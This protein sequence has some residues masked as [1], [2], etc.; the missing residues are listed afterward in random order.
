MHPNFRTL[1][2]LHVGKV[3][4]FLNIRILNNP[5]WLLANGRPDSLAFVSYTAAES[6]CH[7][8]QPS[9]NGFPPTKWHSS[10]GQG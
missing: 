1:S 6:G 10:L 8:P 5:I 7:E 3:Y 2:R 4:G 9:F